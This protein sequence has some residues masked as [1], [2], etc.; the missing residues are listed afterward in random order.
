MKNY[1]QQLIKCTDEVQ[2]LCEM[3]GQPTVEI[4]IKMI[5]E[6][7][8]IDCPLMHQDEKKSFD[9]CGKDIHATKG[10][11]QC[12]QPQT[13]HLEHTPVPTKMMQLCENINL[14]V[15]P[16]FQQFMHFP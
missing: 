16:F 2:S 9:I 7:R 14:C 5:E 4:L 10:K 12:K 8:M 15:D 13:L 3:T 1:I 6:G 11:P